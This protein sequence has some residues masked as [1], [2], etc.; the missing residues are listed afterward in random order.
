MHVLA[1]AAQAFPTDSLFRPRCTGA[2]SLLGTTA[3][4]FQTRQPGPG[5]REQRRANPAVPVS[6]LTG[7]PTRRM[8][9]GFH[10]AKATHSQGKGRLT[11]APK[12]TSTRAI[13][14]RSA[15]L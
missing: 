7:E 14:T 5:I 3:L 4:S 13:E 11:T 8:K 9:D 6:F 1:A 12:R 2:T 10:S 15:S